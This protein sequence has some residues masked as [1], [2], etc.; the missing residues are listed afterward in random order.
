MTSCCSIAS[1]EVRFCGAAAELCCTRSVCLILVAFFHVVVV[2]W[3][4]VRLLPV[5]LDAIYDKGAPDPSS[6]ATGSSEMPSKA[7][8]PKSSQYVKRHI[9][10]NVSPKLERYES[11]LKL[12]FDN[13]GAVCL[14]QMSLFVLFWCCL[15]LQ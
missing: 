14:S 3:L 15:S 10:P 12:G 4:H 2:L 13:S 6:T 9:K 8:S 7:E 5:L 1:T 11:K